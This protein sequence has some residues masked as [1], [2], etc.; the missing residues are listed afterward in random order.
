MFAFLGAFL[1]EL[2]VKQIVRVGNNTQ[3]LLIPYHVPLTPVGIAAASPAQCGA[4][5]SALGAASAAE[6]M[7]I[8]I[9]KQN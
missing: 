3:W 7:T 5:E 8:F 1:E 4:E 9:D 2:F 6:D